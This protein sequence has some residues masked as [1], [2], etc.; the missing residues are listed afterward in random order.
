ME[1]EVQMKSVMMGLSYNQ[2]L[3]QYHIEKNE[4]FKKNPTA[5][6][7]ECDAKIREL[8]RKYKV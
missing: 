3:E 2:R 4:W 1:S 6:A 5:T 7:A 8:S